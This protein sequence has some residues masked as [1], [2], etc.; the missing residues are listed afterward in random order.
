M[1]YFH[2]KDYDTR[3]SSHRR[4]TALSAYIYKLYLHLKVENNEKKNK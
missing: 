3:K 1:F 4:A 2:T